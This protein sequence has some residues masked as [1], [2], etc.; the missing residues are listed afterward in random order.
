MTTHR[1]PCLIPLYLEFKSPQLL[2]KVSLL[3]WGN[4][5]TIVTLPSKDG[6]LYPFS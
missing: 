4:L 5:L 2:K 6:T 1:L 3:D